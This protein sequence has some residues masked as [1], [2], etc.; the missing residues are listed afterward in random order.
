M[1]TNTSTNTGT[2]TATTAD[3]DKRQA[4]IDGLRDL[5]AYLTEHPDVPIDGARVHF[6]VMAADDAEGIAEV[7]AIAK[8]VD[9]PVTEGGGRPVTAK[10]A[11]TTG[12][13]SG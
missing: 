2:A 9:T 11:F 13:P 5:A 7:E 1:T 12:I 3:T 8:A 10:T 4:V 6:C